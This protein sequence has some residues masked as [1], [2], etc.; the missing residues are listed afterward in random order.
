MRWPSCPTRSRWA[1]GG[2]RGGGAGAKWLVWQGRG[3]AARDAGGRAGGAWLGRRRPAG[4]GAQGLVSASPGVSVAGGPAADACSRLPPAPVAQVAPFK[5]FMD[6]VVL[7][8]AL[9]VRPKGPAA[10]PPA[11]P[12]ALQHAAGAPGCSTHAPPAAGA[13]DTPSFV[14][15]RLHACAAASVSPSCL[16]SRAPAPRPPQDKYLAIKEER[17][18]LEAGPDAMEFA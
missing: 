6:S 3:A 15:P 1:E 18:E 17:R 14:H 7:G 2:A 16:S 9:K 10:A 11:L 8:S 5:Q 4:A 12:R 13:L